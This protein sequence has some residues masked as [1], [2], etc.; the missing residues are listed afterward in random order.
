MDAEYTGK[1][2]AERRKALGLTQKALAERLH[3][4]DKAVSK[5]ERGVNFPDLGL[6]ESLALALDTTPACLLGLEHA[7]PKEIVTSITQ[8]SAE[9]AGESQRHIARISWTNTVCAILLAIAY[10]FI[11]VNFQ[12]AGVY[13]Q[14]RWVLH[15]LMGMI[16]IQ[17][18]GGL[19]LLRSYGEIKPWNVEELFLFY[20]I[21]FPVLI[22][23]GIQFLTGY[24]P[25]PAFGLLLLGIGSSCTQ[26]L[27]FRT[28]RPHWAK[29]LPLILTAAY[30]LWEIWLGNAV[31]GYI[32][33]AVCCLAAWLFCL[34]KGHTKLPTPKRLLAVVCVF[35]ILLLILFFVFYPN[36]VRAYVNVR[37][38]HLEAYAESSLQNGTSTSY[39]LWSV[40]IYPEQGMVQF[41]T[42]GSGLAPGS[43]YEGFYY[44][45]EDT[46]IPFQGFDLEMEIDGDTAYW[47]EPE[48]YSDN[49]GTSTRIREHW[50]WFE[51]H[52]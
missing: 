44:S 13:F 35:L 8:V 33:P 43:V 15:L 4:T 46:H 52:F 11:S 47:A 51:W 6:M 25:H 42:G 28:L 38:E 40:Y 2:I 32:L 45:A 48:E 10:Y 24:D 23:L 17:G 30:A 31:I 18:I 7:D 34:W 12:R 27:F 37:H 1:Q 39:G 3:V 41:N 21:L 9:Q 14:Y 36:L 5:W 20:G 26:F 49:W 19:Y 16:L 50:F 29:A 22:Y